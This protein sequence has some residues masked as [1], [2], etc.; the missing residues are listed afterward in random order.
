MEKKELSVGL[1]DSN[2]IADPRLPTAEEDQVGVARSHNTP[3]RQ[4]KKERNGSW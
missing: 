4:S 2:R 1:V 3:N